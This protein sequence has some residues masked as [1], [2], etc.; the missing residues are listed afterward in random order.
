MQVNQPKE[1]G[2]KA[3]TPPSDTA[4][5]ITCE[6]IQQYMTGGG[7]P[8]AGALGECAAMWCNGN[9]WTA[10]LYM[11]NPDFH[12]SAA[13]AG[14]F[15]SLGAS[16]I[17][18]THTLYSTAN[19]DRD[20]QCFEG[21]TRQWLVQFTMRK[22]PAP[23][24]EPAPAQDE[25]Q[26]VYVECRECTECGHAGIN[27]QADGDSACS[28]CSWSGA[29]PDEDKCPECQR[30]GTMSA[31]CPKCGCRYRLIADAEIATSIAETGQQPAQSELVEALR[32]AERFIA[33]FEGCELQEGIDELLMRIRAAQSELGG[34]HA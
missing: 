17:E 33:G 8:T 15:R 22:A 31:S 7:C 20:G 2:T 13:V 1:G 32:E 5:P 19:G 10:A 21:V 11:W 23:H 29:S 25:R 14:W 18:I 26:P 24:A 3:T 6:Q 30:E 9:V 16:E 4:A 12:D 27:D 28:H 34:S